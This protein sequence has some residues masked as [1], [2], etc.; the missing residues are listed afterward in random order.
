MGVAEIGTRQRDFLPLATRKI[1]SAFKAPA[2]HL[3]ILMRKSFDHPVRHALLGGPVQEFQI[4]DLFNPPHANILAGRHLVSHKVLEDDADFPVEILQAIFPQVHPIEE[5]LPLDRIVKPGH[6]L[7]DGG[8]AF[9]VL[10]NQGHALPGKQRKIQLLQNHPRISRILERDIAKLE[11]PHDGPRRGQGL[12]LG[13]NGG[14]HLEKSQQ[15][16]EEQRLVCNA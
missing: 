2:E 7:D 1:H 13:T 15:I 14:L 4:A 5:N 6:E 16:G 9:P 3:F 11:S 10:P 12:R 8:F